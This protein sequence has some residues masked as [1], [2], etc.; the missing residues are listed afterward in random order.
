MAKNVL[1]LCVVAVL[2][3]II[4]SFGCLEGKKKVEAEEPALEETKP[5]VEQIVEGKQVTVAETKPAVAE[6]KTTEEKQQ[7]AAKEAK[8]EPNKPGVLVT[9]NGTDITEKQVDEFLQ[10]MLKSRAAANQQISE[11]AVERYKSQILDDMISNLILEQ[12]LKAYNIS[13]AEQDVNDVIDKL[14]SFSD[15]PMTHDKLKSLLEAQGR[16]VEQWK[17]MM[18]FKR[19]IQMERLMKAIHPEKLDVNDG[20]AKKFY[21]ENPKFFNFPEQVRASHILIKPEKTDPNNVE[22]AKAAAREKAEGLLKQIREGANFEELAK[23]HS[24]CPSAKMGGDL[25]LFGREGMIPAFS[26]AAFAL[27][28]G[29]MSDVVETSAGFHIIKLTEHKEP[30][31]IPF[32]KAKDRIIYTLKDQKLMESA[33]ELIKELKD[34]ANI[35]YPPGSDLRA[36]QPVKS[37]IRRGTENIL[38]APAQ[39]KQTKPADTNAN[40]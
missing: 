30:Y 12:Q 21:D 23:E 6:Q 28:V 14:L 37:T 8:Q 20:D 24:A 22:Q 11:S 34:K 19:K 16:T 3:C 15:P 39:N 9:V 35:V 7:E 5:A 17:Q 38:Q 25:G 26:N 31:V 13:V 32:E 40:K 29:E 27:K 33:S 2:T 4:F 18:G 36:Y 1:N 10:P